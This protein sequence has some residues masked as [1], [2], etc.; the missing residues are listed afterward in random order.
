MDTQ[1][2][3]NHPSVGG[4]AEVARDL[5]ITQSAVSQWLDDDVI[6]PARLKY[7]KLRYPEVPWDQYAPGQNPRKPQKVAA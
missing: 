3:I 5:E 7:F 1:T 2:A 6:P 4:A